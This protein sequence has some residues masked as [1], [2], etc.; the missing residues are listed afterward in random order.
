VEANEQLNHRRPEA[1]VGDNR[2]VGLG[3]EK[4]GRAHLIMNDFMKPRITTFKGLKLALQEQNTNW[5]LCIYNIPI[6]RYI[7]HEHFKKKLYN[8]FMAKMTT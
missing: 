6:Y 1:Q 7:N 5:Q 4:T 8:S 3:M 2:G